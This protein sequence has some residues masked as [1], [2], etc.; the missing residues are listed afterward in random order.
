MK[1]IKKHLPVV[2]GQLSQENNLLFNIILNKKRMSI[3]RIKQK[4]ST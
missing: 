2:S 3:D 1:E 4:I